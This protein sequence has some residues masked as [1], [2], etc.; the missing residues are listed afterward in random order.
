MKYPEDLPLLTPEDLEDQ[1]EGA[2]ECVVRNGMLRGRACIFYA[3]I[4]FSL[5]LTF[6]IELPGSEEPETSEEEEPELVEDCEVVW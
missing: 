1:P 5:F 4:N 3:R 6:Q 2:D